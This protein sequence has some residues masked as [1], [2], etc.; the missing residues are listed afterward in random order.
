[1]SRIGIR[2]IEVPG[3][4]TISVDEATNVVSIAGP[5]GTLLQPIS[6]LLSVKQEDGKVQIERPNNLREARSQH[7]LARTLLANMVEGVTKGH[8]KQLDVIGV[9]Y[10]ATM[11]GKNLLLN[12][13][14]SHPVRVAAPEGITL[15]VKA[16]DKARTQSIIVSGIDKALVGQ[17][18]ADIRKVRKPEPYKGKGIRYQGEVIKLKAGKRASAKK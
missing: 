11:E 17:V 7:G 13:G 1:M 9:G 10:R 18:A 16:D 15:E 14:Y 3:N 8:S 5:K 6:R 12:M 2:P 4:V